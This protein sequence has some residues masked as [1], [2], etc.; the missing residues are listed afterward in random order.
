M[1]HSTLDKN[2]LFNVRDVMWLDNNKYAT[3]YT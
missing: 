2:Y 1:Q 3:K